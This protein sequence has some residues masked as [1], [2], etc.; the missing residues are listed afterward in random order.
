MKDFF[1]GDKIKVKG[2]LLK[3]ENFK[4]DLNSEFDYVSFLKKNS[5][6]Y[7]VQPISVEYLSSQN[8]NFIKQKLLNLKRI[9]LNKIKKMIRE[10]EASLL[11]GLILGAKEDMGKNLL[12]DFRKTG[13]IHIVVLS[14]YNLSLVADF[15][16]KILSFFGLAISS[17]FGSL[18]I[19]FFTIMTGASATIVRAALM[20]LLIIFA[21]N[22]GRTAA[23]IRALF[24][25][26][27]IMLAFNPMLIL[28]DPSFQL[29]FMATFGLIILSPKMEKFFSFV[30]KTKLD[31]RGIL[32]ATLATQIFVLPLILYM[33]GSVSIISPI[34]NLLIL[35]FVPLTMLTGFLAV[36]FSFFSFP[37]ASI[38]AFISFIFLFYD[39]KVV[40]YFANFSFSLFEY[41]SFGIKYLLFLYFIYFLI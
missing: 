2:Y 1:Y 4:T 41:K 30:P 40:E 38:F 15:F 25:A 27:F 39:L 33:M 10:P 8:G 5:I 12:E 32:S 37:L 6:F 34:V 22:S 31:F 35:I 23:S 36:V 16:M 28:Y 11:G 20:A 7:K 14:G 18:A 9:F 26:A 17:I 21:K 13:V 19:I 24:I 29:S 3:P